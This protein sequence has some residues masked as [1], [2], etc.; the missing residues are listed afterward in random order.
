M[1]FSISKLQ[2]ISYA[3]YTISF[4]KD[5][6]FAKLKRHPSLVVVMEDLYHH[7]YF[8]LRI[9]APKEATSRNPIRL[10]I[11]YEPIVC[12]HISKY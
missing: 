11:A 9:V 6:T 8:A 12:K 10:S 5:W 3:L 1:V 4:K 2:P 7:I